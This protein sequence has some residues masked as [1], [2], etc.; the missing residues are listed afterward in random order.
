M[1]KIVTGATLTAALG[2]SLFAAA[3]ATAV[4]APFANCT[5]AYEEGYSHIPSTHPRF[6]P[7]LDANG[8]GVG[9]EGRQNLERLDK[10]AVNDSTDYHD[11]T[12]QALPDAAYIYPDCKDAYAAGV[13]NIPATHPDYHDDLDSDQDGVGC[14]YNVEYGVVVEGREE[15]AAAE[16]EAIKTG[17]VAETEDESQVSVVPV[18]PAETGVAPAA[19]PAAAF[20]VGALGLAGVAGAAVLVRRRA[21]A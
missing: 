8:D 3:P 10:P 15:A 11:P 17:A 16:I 1:K 19:D 7:K 5:A 20:A 9:C 4:E 14:E 13:F 2:L 21:Q 6:Q 12:D 18:G